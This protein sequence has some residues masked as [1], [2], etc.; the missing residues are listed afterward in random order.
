MTRKKRKKPNQT[1]FFQEA[2]KSVDIYFTLR[3]MQCSGFT[4]PKRYELIAKWMRETFCPRTLTHAKSLFI[5]ALKNC[6]HF[7]IL[8]FNKQ[9]WIEEWAFSHPIQELL[10]ASHHALYAYTEED[11]STCLEAVEVS[12]SVSLLLTQVVMRI[13]SKKGAKA[14]ELKY[15][16]K[17][18]ET[19]CTKQRFITL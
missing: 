8:F 1:A 4:S 15:R 19:T 14:K 9:V 13:P 5:S 17:A 18:N 11:G 2:L 7:D 12:D 6:S 16:G 10:S 3:D